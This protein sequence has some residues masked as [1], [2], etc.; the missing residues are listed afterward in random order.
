MSYCTITNADRI[1]L[2]TA[3]LYYQLYSVYEKGHDNFLFF[4]KSDVFLRFAFLIIRNIDS[5]SLKFY[6]T[7][8]VISHIDSF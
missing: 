6:K 5:V 4:L 1:Y 2:S 7:R 8:A 3:L